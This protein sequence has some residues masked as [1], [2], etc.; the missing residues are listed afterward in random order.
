[1]KEYT[2]PENV[3]LMIATPAFSGQVTVEYCQSFAKTCHHL[4]LHKIPITIFIRKSGSLLIAERNRILQRFNNS[5]CTH[6]L[7]IDSDI[8]WNYEDVFSL[9][10]RQKEIIAACYLARGQN[11][12][13]F[14]P[15]NQEYLDIGND[16]LIEMMA[17]PAGF[18]MISKKGLQQMIENLPELYYCPKYPNP[19]DKDDGYA[20]FNTM[21]YDKEFWGEDF[22]F[23]LRAREAG[24]KIW[25]DPQ[26]ELNH[27]GSKGKLIDAINE[28]PNEDIYVKT[29]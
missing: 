28:I 4:S 15:V 5:D 23:C 16:G 25:V 10:A 13:V 6:L 12:Y 29:P 11:R 24:L 8:A 21:V 17:V 1:M 22:S 7:C 18:L 20:F 26:I 2:L 27:A 3:S 9:L 19:E 14:R